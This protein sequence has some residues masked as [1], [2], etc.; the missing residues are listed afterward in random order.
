[1]VFEGM[2]SAF[3]SIRTSMDELNAL[4]TL[5]LSVTTFPK[6]IGCL[7]EMLSTEAVTTIRLECFCAAIADT[8]SIQCM[9]RPPIRLFNVLVSL[10][11]TS[12]VMLTADSLGVFRFRDIVNQLIEA[13]LKCFE[14][15]KRC[16]KLIIVSSC[17]NHKKYFA[18]KYIISLFRILKCKR[19]IPYHFL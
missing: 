8:I 6:R 3:T 11:R 19:F 1:M 10:G 14:D 7:K 5:A 16:Q 15:H 17:K 2:S 18:I 4:V 9:R 12:S 13:T